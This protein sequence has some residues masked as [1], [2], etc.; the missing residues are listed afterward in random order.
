MF[1]SKNYTS[2]NLDLQDKQSRKIPT[3]R[4][5]LRDGLVYVHC[6]YCGKDHEHGGA[7]NLGDALNGHVLAHCGRGGYFIRVAKAADR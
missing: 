7:R 4:G 2:D 5:F 3:I 1:F 6:P